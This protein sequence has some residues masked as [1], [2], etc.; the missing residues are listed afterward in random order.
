MED[1][2]KTLIDEI[3]EDA[4]RRGERRKRRAEREAENIRSRARDRAQE[5]REEI[6]EEGREKAARAQER[7]EAT[8]SL[9]VAAVRQEAIERILA[10]ARA[11]AKER[12]RE[13]RG[14][15]GYADDLLRLAVTAIDHMQ[16]DEFELAPAGPD[17]EVVDD[18]FCERLKEQVEDELDRDVD[19][20]V[21]DRTVEGSG[22]MQVWTEDGTELADQTF[23]ARLERLWAE[24]RVH[25]ADV[26]LD[27]RDERE[28]AD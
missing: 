13:R 27:G 25:V 2:N 23:E 12:L 15:D 26:L 5:E 14:E 28:E 16:S 6:L 18:D 21:A 10:H 19:V 11:T 1:A 9:E 24:L 20:S 22:G 8:V 7:I 3:L 4:R 17:D